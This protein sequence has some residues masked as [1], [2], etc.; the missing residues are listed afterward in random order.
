M[1]R[2]RLRGNAVSTSVLLGII[3][4]SFGVILAVIFLVISFVVVFGGPRGARNALMH[5]MI[6][7]FAS[8]LTT[9]SIQY[10]IKRRR[11]RS[12]VKGGP[13]APTLTHSNG[14]DTSMAIFAINDDRDIVMTDDED[15]G[16]TPASSEG[17]RK[18]EDE[19]AVFPSPTPAEVSSLKRLE[20]DDG[21]VSSPPPPQVWTPACFD[22]RDGWELKLT[23]SGSAERASVAGSVAES[24]AVSEATVV[25]A[26]RGVTSAT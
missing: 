1:L 19:M 22:I 6:A 15:I 26:P 8:P 23:D 20:E 21:D 2:V 14:H 7:N 16:F 11:R 18:R 17:K 9:A 24:V 5:P 10:V 12:V 13:H 4:I 3:I 25:E